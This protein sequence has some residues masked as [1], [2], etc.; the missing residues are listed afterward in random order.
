MEDASGLGDGTRSP[1]LS[2][3]PLSQR[4]QPARPPPARRPPAHPQPANPRLAHPRPA[5]PRLARPQPANPRQARPRPAN[6]RPLQQR[7]P[8]AR[9]PAFQPEESS[10]K[11]LKS[12]QTCSMV[13]SRYGTVW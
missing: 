1:S 2:D 13:C 6:P 12:F 9:R 7:A 11:F 4:L 10:G 3:V 8:R 5:N